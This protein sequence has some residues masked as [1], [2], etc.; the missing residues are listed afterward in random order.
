MPEPAK[1]E[2]TPPAT[3]TSSTVKSAADSL[4]VN[5]RTA[6]SPAFSLPWLVAMAMVGGFVSM[7][8]DG[9]SDPARLALPAAS[10]NLP[11]A[12]ETVPDPVKPADGVNFAV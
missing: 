6:V 1:F 2:S 8:N 11:A 3:T 4:S 12:T 10:V 5:V 7:A 9:E